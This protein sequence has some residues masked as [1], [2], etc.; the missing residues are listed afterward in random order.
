M[1]EAFLQRPLPPVLETLLQQRLAVLTDAL[2]E[3]SLAQQH[4]TGRALV[5][6]EFIFE[7]LR[8]RPALLAQLWQGPLLAESLLSAVL[9]PALQ[10]ALAPVQTELELSQALRRFREF[11]Q[12][13]LCWFDL[14]GRATLEQVMRFASELAEVCVDEAAKWLYRFE[15]ERVGVPC[16]AQGTP[17]PLLVLGM[18]KL[19]GYELNVSSDIDL[20]FVYPQQGETQGAKRSLSNEQFFVRL[21]Q[22][23]IAALSQITAEGQPFRVDMRLRPY[24]D[25]GRLAMSFAG[26][27]EYYFHI[28]R[29][30]ERYAMVKARVIS[31][32]AAEA[33]QLM[34]LL[35]PFVYRRYLDFSA[36]ESLRQMKRLI[37]REVF[38]KSR[39]D[40]IKLGAGGIR[41]V[42]F[43]AQVFQI[44]RGGVEI[45]LQEPSLL[46]VLSLLGAKGDLPQAVVTE[47]QSS[48]RFLRKL[49]HALQELADQQTQ[50]LPADE[51][52]R[53]RLAWI[54]ECENWQALYQQIQQQMQ[55]V[56]RHFDAVI[57]DP[58]AEPEPKQAEP[59]LEALWQTPLQPQ[60]SEQLELLN[61][62]GFQLEQPQ[63]FLN[64]L[65]FLQSQ[66]HSRPLGER[67]RDRFTRL[68]PKL[69]A[70][71][72]QRANPTLLLSRL[73]PVLDAILCRTT[74]I[75]LLLEHGVALDNLL[76]LCEASP[77]ISELLARHPL[78]LDELLDS[79]QLLQSPTQAEMQSELSQMLLRIPSEDLEQQMES[80]RQFK[81]AHQLHIA[82]EDLLA[83]L[84]LMR[85]SDQLTFLA[86][87]L[88]QEAI[89]LAWRQL[90]E[91]HG[92]PPEP[93]SG[94]GLS[95]FAIIAYGKLGGIE[96]GYGSDLDLVFVHQG[97]SEADTLG[98]KPI[99]SQVFFV[100][101][102][103]KLIHLISIR[104]HSGLL[105][106]VDTRLRP[107]GSSG[108]L[109]SHIDSFARY[110][111]NEAW[112]WEHQ[113]LI[114]A[115]FIAG[116]PRLGEQ[117]EQVRASVLSRPREPDTLRQQVLEMRNKMREHLA[118]DKSGRFHLKQDRGGITD[119]EFIVQYL[120]LSHA[121]RHPTLLQWTDN[122][123]L[124]QTLAELALLSAEQ[125][126]AL[127]R[128]YLAFRDQGH[129]LSL[130]NLPA[131]VDAERYA[132]LRQP[133]Q[134][135]W[136]ELFEPLV[137]E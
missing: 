103:Q 81:Q 69:L 126:D 55:Q 62:A 10:L 33:G 75:E 73:A 43:I 90:A 114:R 122:V 27:H 6:S 101:L 63:E 53:A 15:S 16:D 42:E 123:R 61:R 111:Q 86:E 109:V 99:P 120:V 11:Y 74:Y 135:L 50:T 28:G 45:E 25:S 95:G 97:D 102:A 96:L 13:L 46:R 44:I 124:L 52:N 32:P 14:L 34:K 84:P 66:V 98:G 130:Q 117:F 30:W 9:R 51:L 8:A 7:R 88:L 31:G 107:S 105:Y 116:D 48:Y 100:K 57:A 1:S 113:A 3:L 132:D 128:A 38:R 79:R 37:E 56:H 4:E 108:L 41:E 22:K 94:G 39:I 29:E 72:R 68:M 35:K 26:I 17:Q 87:T 93:D 104:T 70:G 115:R 91:R 82:A 12:L 83:N 49:E 80:L 119:I 136:S 2:A 58:A 121:H 59:V 40:N 85:V 20:I 19:G 18:G 125:A 92:R 47:L 118:P 137:A 23:L 36:I 64:Q 76:T 24:G 71:V 106:E 78:L 112:T 5:L 60:L 54:F 65:L 77:W 131:E 127:R 133:V 89:Q 129:K 134:A 21:G 67:G 110:Q